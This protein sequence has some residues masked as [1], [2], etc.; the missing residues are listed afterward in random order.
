MARERKLYSDLAH[1]EEEK[2]TETVTSSDVE[3]Y[4]GNEYV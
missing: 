3:D 1:N 2:V 4:I